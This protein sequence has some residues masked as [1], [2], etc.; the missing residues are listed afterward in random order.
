MNG[1]E[2]LARLK[3][4]KRC[5]STPVMAFSAA[6]TTADIDAA[7]KSGFIHYLTK[8]INIAEVTKLISSIITK[9][10]S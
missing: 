5:E 10:V 4:M 3:Q 2:V 8:P 9:T 7:I 1:H 6:A